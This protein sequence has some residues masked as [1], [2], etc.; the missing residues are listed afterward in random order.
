MK[1]QR[2][3]IFAIAAIIF[4]ALQPVRANSQGASTPPDLHVAYGLQPAAQDANETSQEEGSASPYLSESLVYTRP[5]FTT[6]TSG[7]L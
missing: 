3:L 6:L 2:K 4:A 5:C 7:T 1:I